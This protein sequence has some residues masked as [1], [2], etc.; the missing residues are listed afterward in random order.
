[1][2]TIP[3]DAESVFGELGHEG[4]YYADQIPGLRVDGS[5]PFV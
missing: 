3:V 2:P 4:V 1:M 5:L